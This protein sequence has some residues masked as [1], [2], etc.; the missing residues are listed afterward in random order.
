MSAWVLVHLLDVAPRVWW[1]W[2]MFVVALATW[3][4]V[5]ALW[6]VHTWRRRREVVFA[7]PLPTATAR[8]AAPRRIKV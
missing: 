1:G 7:A 3:A 5:I 4:I 6:F 2:W 8:F